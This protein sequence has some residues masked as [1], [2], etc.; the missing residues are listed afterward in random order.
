MYYFCDQCVD[1]YDRVYGDSVVSY[2]DVLN[3]IKNDTK[4]LKQ[5]KLLW[6][7]L[8]I[9]LQSNL[10][11][12]KYGDRYERLNEFRIITPK[13]TEDFN[14][15]KTAVNTLKDEMAVYYSTNFNAGYFEY[16]KIIETS[17]GVIFKSLTSL[18]NL[19]PNTLIQVH[20]RSGKT[21]IISLSELSKYLQDVIQQDKIKEVNLWSVCQKIKD[22][23]DG[24]AA[25]E[26][27]Q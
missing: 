17:D 7:N 26:K 8:I 14:D 3:S 24:F 9:N 21:D 6:T 5:D 11:A 13:Y 27:I 1:W 19:E 23:D 10:E 16:A 25:F 4:L 2:Y 18:D 22:I 15:L 12:I 20:S